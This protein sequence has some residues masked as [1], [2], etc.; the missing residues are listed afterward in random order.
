MNVKFKLQADLYQF[1]YHYLA[2]L[3]TQRGFSRHRSWRH[4]FAYLCY[5]LHIA[6][7][8]KDEKPATL[9]DI[10]CGD[11]RLLSLIEPVSGCQAT[12]ID[13]CPQAIALAQAMNPERHFICATAAELATTFAMVTCIDVIEHLLDSEIPDFI[14]A[15][16]ARVEPGGLLLIGVPTI[17]QP[18]PAKH[19]RHYHEKLLLEHLNPEAHALTVSDVSYVFNGKDMAYRLYSKITENRLVFCAVQALENLM[20]H[21]VWN[22]LRCANAAN[23][24]QLLVS[25]RKN[26]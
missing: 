13:P 12:G 9:L 5:Q 8:I 21:R 2:D 3:H 15:V 11:G 26:G 14:S 10:G 16:A 20:W 7:L 24:R 18:V 4:G 23:G 25:L 1:P 6:L 22:R 17:N 19:Y